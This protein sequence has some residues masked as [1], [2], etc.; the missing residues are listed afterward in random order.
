M[1]EGE[2]A[3]KTEGAMG[4][5][6]E[7]PLRLMKRVYLGREIERLSWVLLKKEAT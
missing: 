6:S 2:L 7:G 1:G 4:E 5:L 3:E